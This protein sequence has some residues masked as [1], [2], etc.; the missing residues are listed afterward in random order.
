MK[1]TRQS[2]LE[3]VKNRSYW[4]NTSYFKKLVKWAFN[5]CD[6]QKKG[7]V[8]KA[9]LY[10]GVLM[11]HLKLAK[12]FGPAATFPPTREVVN[13][14]F[15]A[16]D[17]D[18]SGDIDEEEFITVMIVL[19]SQITSRIVAYYTILIM[20]VPYLIRLIIGFLDFIGV[21]VAIMGVDGLFD[22]YAPQIL[23]SIVGLIPDETWDTMPEMIVSLA[24]FYLVIPIC[25]DWMDSYFRDLA[26][27]ES[28]KQANIADTTK[29]TKTE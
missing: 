26:A 28:V 13:Q 12:Y 5:I 11:V 27:K 2:L 7:S 20:L 23:Q 9:E 25:W 17:V 3:S 16:S 29:E 4:T 15:D 1:W 21:D 10:V 22:K 14:L 8:T 18:K 19:C 6:D 24:L